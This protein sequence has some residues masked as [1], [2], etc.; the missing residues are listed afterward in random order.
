MSASRGWSDSSQAKPAAEIDMR[1]GHQLLSKNS[2]SWPRYL[3]I[4]SPTAFRVAESYLA[5]KPADVAYIRSL[6]YSYLQQVA[7]GLPDD[8]ELVIGLGGGQA[9]DAA[10]HMAVAK[11]LPLILVPT[12]VSTGAIIHGHC[13]KYR[14]NTLEGDRSSWVWADCE[15]VLV[16]YDLTL[17]AP[18]H[19]HTA[20]LG[21]VLCGY[22][23]IAEWR[24]NHRDSLETMTDYP[25]LAALER[26]HTSIVDNFP[27][28]LDEHG[29]LT[30]ESIRF[31]MDTLQQRDLYRVRVASAPSADH[32]FLFA[33]QE[34]NNNSWIHGEIVALG[35]LIISWRCNE[36]APEFAA[37]LDRCRVRRRPSQLGVEREELRRGLAYLQDYLAQRPNNPEYNSILREEPIAGQQFDQLWEFLETA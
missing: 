31:I 20:G 26:F 30:A 36:N 3:A 19:L 5:T 16:D 23:G 15:Y 13:P 9:L 14:E 18:I 21:D 11:D 33:L 8:A 17:E 24:R 7:D 37:A 4:T 34:I 29:E 28:T 12:I 22:S 32:A 27:T 1:Y 6:D 2:A 25:D 35:A 10:K